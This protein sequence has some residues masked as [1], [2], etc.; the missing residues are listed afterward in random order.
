M[1]KLKN[2]LNSKFETINSKFQSE[3][4]NNDKLIN[5]SMM[6]YHEEKVI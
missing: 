6:S 4:S 5:I 1:I 3:Q 2:K